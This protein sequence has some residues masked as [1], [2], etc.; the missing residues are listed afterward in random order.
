MKVKEKRARPFNPNR[1]TPTSHRDEEEDDKWVATPLN[2]VIPV[3]VV[4][5]T[6]WAMSEK[7]MRTLPVPNDGQFGPMRYA[8]DPRAKYW[9]NY[10]YDIQPRQGRRHYD[11]GL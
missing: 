1:P 9:G 3:F 6:L 11:R 4:V 2:G 7:W 5:A 8:N 10:R